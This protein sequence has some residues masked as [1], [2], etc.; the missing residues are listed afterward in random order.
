[1]TL[2][3]TGRYALK[4]MIGQALRGLG[5]RDWAVQRYIAAVRWQ[6][7]L[8]KGQHISETSKCRARLA[9]FCVG[10]GLDLGFGGDPI[11]PHAIRMDMPQPY[12]NVGSY[13]VQLGGDA[14]NLHWF[15]DDSLDFIY[16][17][18]LLED[19]EDT[20]SVLKEWLRVLKPGGRLIIFCPDEQVYREYCKKTGHPYNPHHKQEFFSLNFVKDVLRN[21]GQT[22]IL[23]ENPL[24]DIYSWEVV[25]EKQ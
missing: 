18:H 8:G 17:S 4:R 9:P 2:R 5:I 10:Y 14:H 13:P 19:Y 25:C 22:K 15:R 23:Y 16:S 3:E 6:R 11:T 12:T 7:T 21:L 24:I 1:M 20:E